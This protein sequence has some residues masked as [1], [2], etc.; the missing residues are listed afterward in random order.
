MVPVTTR[1]VGPR[2]TPNEPVGER[3]HCGA[4][5]YA[6]RALTGYRCMCYN[7]KLEF[8]EGAKKLQIFLLLKLRKTHKPS[9][10]PTQFHV[11]RVS[12]LVQY[13][14]KVNQQQF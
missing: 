13:Q 2:Q 11:S 6:W 10:I 7:Q 5:R 3:A 9:Q 14:E 1:L 4:S 12:M 8:R